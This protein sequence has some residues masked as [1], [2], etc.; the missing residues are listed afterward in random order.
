MGTAALGKTRPEPLHPRL[1]A[2]RGRP[3][4]PRRAVSTV[5]VSQEEWYP[6]PVPALVEPAVVAAVQ[7]QWQ[8][9]RRHARQ[10]R[11]GALSVLHGLR[12]CQHCGY[13]SS[14]KRLSPRARQGPPRAYASERCLGTE[15]YRCGGER[16]CQ[17][18]QVR[19]A[20]LDGAVWQEVCTRLAHPERLAEAYR[21]RGQP[22]TR[23]KRTSLAT[24]AAQIGKLRP[25]VAR[26]IDS[27]A[28]GLIDKDEFAPRIPRLRQRLA[29]L[30]AQRQAGAAAAAVQTE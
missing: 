30:E 5:D 1:R 2:Q 22:E 28:E 17:H 23:A 18:S 24:V 4:Q 21:R 10:S 16:V 12:Q 13:A 9:H 26:W 8:E 7:E 11:R 29:R 27:S 20:R 14:G 6:M 25:G 15:A 3:L 19:T